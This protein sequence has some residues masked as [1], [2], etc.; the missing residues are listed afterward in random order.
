[1]TGTGRKLDPFVIN[2]QEEL[3]ELAAFTLQNPGFVKE[4]GLNYVYSENY[5]HEN[6]MTEEEEA[7]TEDV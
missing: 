6:E 1:M 4:N 7:E 5:V 2:S 3:Q